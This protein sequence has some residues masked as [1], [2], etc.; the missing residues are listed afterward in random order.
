MKIFNQ[1]N[2]EN[3]SIALIDENNRKVSYSNLFELRNKF[4]SFFKKRSLTLFL[5]SNSIDSIII[6]LSLLKA[7]SVPIL[8]ESNTDK[9]F[10]K[11]L[12]KQYEPDYLLCPSNFS[13]E[14]DGYTQIYKS[15]NY[16][17]FQTKNNI[18]NIGFND[19]LAVLMSTSGSTGSPKLVR[20][21]YNNIYSN[22]DSICKYFNLKKMIRLLQYFQ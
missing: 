5:T 7:K 19:E 8:I 3:K 12:I 2:P 21:S 1:I 17:F 10:I 13:F 15:N 9:E 14:L 20:I 18:E 4:S 11:N 16:I 22:T 6:Y